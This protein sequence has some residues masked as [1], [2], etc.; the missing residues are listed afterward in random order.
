MIR[1]CGWSRLDGCVVDNISVYW[2]GRVHYMRTLW[3]CLRSRPFTL[4]EVLFM[5]IAVVHVGATYI[6]Y[7]LS[8]SWLCDNVFGILLSALWALRVGKSIYTGHHGC[9]SFL[10]LRFHESLVFET[11]PSLVLLGLPPLLSHR[12][13]T[14]PERGPHVATCCLLASWYGSTALGAQ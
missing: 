14:L 6:S 3:E 11:L 10:F 9:N 5:K 8:G 2:A 7:N 13:V 1:D 12:S 4:Q